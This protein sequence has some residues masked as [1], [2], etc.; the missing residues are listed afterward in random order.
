MNGL[1]SPPYSTCVGGT[2]FNDTANPA[3]YGQTTNNAATWASAVSYIPEAAWNESSTVSGGFNSAVTLSTASLP[4]GLTASLS[5]ATLPAPGSGRTTLPLSAATQLAAGT[6][7]VVVP[8]AGGSTDSRV[9][10]YGGCEVLVCS[11]SGERATAAGRRQLRSDGNG[12]R[13][14]RM[15]RQR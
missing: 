1:C 2:Q 11:Q 4:P 14:L 6:Y 9:G 15:D 10:G 8:G 13:R 12:R 3:L 5:P 7:N